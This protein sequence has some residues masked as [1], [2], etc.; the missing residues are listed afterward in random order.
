LPE[1]FFYT[2][3]PEMHM[4]A[5][6]YH[7]IMRKLSKIIVLVI[8]LAFIT[9]ACNAPEK[10]NGTNELIVFHAGSLSKPFH[11]IAEAFE[12]ENPGIK[13]LL[14]AAGSR[15]CARK[16]SEL[17]KPCDIIATSDY[18]VIETLLIPDYAEWQIAFAG[19][20]MC[21]A[22]NSSSRMKNKINSDNWFEVLMNDSVYF[23][24]SDPES[25]PC[26]Y[27]TVI[28]FDLA[29][30]H[31]RTVGLANHLKQ[32]DPEFIRPKEVDML[33]LLESKAID[34]M[35]IYSSVA[36]Q[37]KLNFIELPDEINLSNPTFTEFYATASVELSGKSK[38]DKI[39]QKGEPMIYGISIL[40]NAPNK[41][42]AEKFLTFLLT[43]DKGM[44]I[45][46]QNGQQ[47]IIDSNSK[48]ME[49][50]PKEIKMFLKIEK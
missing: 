18:A 48:Y 10:Q 22:F 26:G 28:M 23:G 19:N 8:T 6:R 1:S 14:E 37:H 42:L 11:E 15:E 17:N 5:Y 41:D 31:Y 34:Y 21:I 7:S 35:F 13:V 30:K 16:I 9:I 39:T 32:K 47:A 46:E 38:D 36:K 3:I 43:S 27:R 25:D 4:C 33:A 20:E 2:F 44:K 50:L 40:K 49:K 45:M 24:R 29:E 12:S